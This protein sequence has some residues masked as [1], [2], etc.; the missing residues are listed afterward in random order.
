MR[1]ALAS[2]VALLAFPALLAAS[3]VDVTFH[4]H[5]AEGTAI[6]PSV[7]LLV[8]SL[9]G[10]VQRTEHL[11][12]KG[13]HIADLPP[14]AWQLTVAGTQLYAAAATVASSGLDETS[15]VEIELYPAA[16]LT[17]AL[18]VSRGEKPVQHLTAA[19]QPS[20]ASASQDI[21]SGTVD[22]NVRDGKFECVVPAGTLDLSLRAASYIPLYRWELAASRGKPVMLENISLK[23]GSSLTGR[24]A[25]GGALGKLDDVRVHVTRD[26]SLPPDMKTRLA[27]QAS[28]VI[29]NARGFFSFVLAPGDYLVDATAPGLISDTRQ[30]RILEGREAELSAPLVLQP[31][32]AL[33]LH[34]TPLRAPGNT[35]WLVTLDKLDRD[36]GVEREITDEVST[37]GEWKRAG[38][39]PGHYLLQLSRI[40][41]DA[42]F[43]RELDIDG[44]TNVDAAMQF[45]KVSGR[46]T[47]GGHPFAAQL[48]MSDDAGERRILLHSL[49][50]G[51]FRAILPDVAAGKWNVAVS[52][53]KP[54]LRRVVAVTVKPEGERH[55][56]HVEIELPGTTVTGEVVDRE[57][58][59]VYPALIDVIADEGTM[60]QVESEDGTFSVTGLAPGRVSF[61]ARTR[62]GS[63]RS[64]VSL[65]VTDTNDSQPVR[66]E[67]APEGVFE[68]VVQTMN[69]PLSD[70][71]VSPLQIDVRGSTIGR[72]PVEADGRFTVAVAP[73]ANEFF[74]LVAAPGY[75]TRLLRPVVQRDP[76]LPLFLS[77][78]GGTLT[79]E[80]PDSRELL[81]M[82]IHD[83][84]MFPALGAMWVSGGAQQVIPGGRRGTI[85]LI[86]P[87]VYTLCWMNEN[88][89]AAA[90]ARADA[91]ADSRCK[92]G[93][94]PPNGT[95]TLALPTPPSTSSSR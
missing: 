27:L 92:S 74:L 77:T 95:L 75:A 56:A 91:G 60:H 24:I 9:D 82:L 6:S 33:T 34:T 83:R 14:S 87:G 37:T 68:G 1:R 53:E 90:A 54:Y 88:D 69:G 20:P 86:E 40:H 72:L 61:R 7:T 78:L 38:L 5:G 39:V 46:L 13:G 3:S 49:A 62:S 65:D 25:T 12:A 80:V 18:Q 17:G 76:P 89:V 67:I 2:V 81:P 52:A 42:W 44:D 16:L 11:T 43:T 51:A 22:C 64:I 30:V 23:H 8:S 35:Q 45:V 41:G 28:S 36:H 10:N 93:I 4:V 94:V 21:P 47:L 26:T 32:R 55:I 73:G 70:A 15:S 48:A 19:F 50:D 84:A 71:T 79:V 85:A 58:K 31:P 63:T 66:L 29:P 59:L 57:G